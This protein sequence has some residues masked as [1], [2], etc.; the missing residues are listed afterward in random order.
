MFALS[1][2]E[3]AR[4]GEEA[5][6]R[7]HVRFIGYA[8]VVFVD[9]CPFDASDS[10]AIV[11]LD[12]LRLGAPLQHMLTLLFAPI[13]FGNEGWAF[14]QSVMLMSVISLLQKSPADRFAVRQESLAEALGVRKTAINNNRAK[15]F[16][17]LPL[18]F[19]LIVTYL[20]VLW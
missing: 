2:T 18:L 4:T 1:R 20:Y 17:I 11:F 3:E 16:F 7:D 19:C 15:Y 14:S 13:A 6:N 9:A 8:E 12:V 5:M 10:H